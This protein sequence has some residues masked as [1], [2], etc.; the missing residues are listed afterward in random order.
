MEL[1]YDPPEGF[2]SSPM[3]TST[4]PLSGVSPPN[5][6]PSVTLELPTTVTFSLCPSADFPSN[7]AMARF[8]SSLFLYLMRTVTRLAFLGPCTNEERTGPQVLKM[9]CGGGVVV[10]QEK[11]KSMDGRKPEERRK[12]TQKEE[13]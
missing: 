11:S 13:I 5:R 1:T 7:S 10:S 4:L 8:A 12:G 3:R 2:A 9:D 6:P